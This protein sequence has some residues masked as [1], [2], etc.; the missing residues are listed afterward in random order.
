MKIGQWVAGDRKLE[1]KGRVPWVISLLL[2]VVE[3]DPQHAVT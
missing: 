3:L 1:E 2:N